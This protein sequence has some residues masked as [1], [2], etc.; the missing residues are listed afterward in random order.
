MNIKILLRW[1]AMPFAAIIG[2]LAAYILISLWIKGNEFGFIAYNG[3]EV[4]HITDI[5]LAIAAQALFGAA[6][7]FFGALTAP[8]HQQTCAIVLATI[9]SILSVGSLIFSIASSGF[10]FLMFIHCLA[11]ATG[12]IIIAKTI[13][14]NTE[15]EEE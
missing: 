1:I 7:V 13:V 11:T 5:I 6:F 10:S 15:N 8:K 9:I 3:I 14:S 4:G 2:S 12:A